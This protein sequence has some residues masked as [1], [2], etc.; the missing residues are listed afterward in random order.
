M[1]YPVPSG[2]I[3]IFPFVSLVATSAVVCTVS[4]YKALRIQT[5]DPWT[6]CKQIVALQVL[7]YISLIVEEVIFVSAPRLYPLM[8]VHGLE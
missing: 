2:A 4:T 6:I 5:W 1:G 7:F 3:R 8:C